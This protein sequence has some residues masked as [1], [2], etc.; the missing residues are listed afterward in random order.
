MSILLLL[1]LLLDSTIGVATGNVVPLITH[2][3]VS[4]LGINAEG[5]DISRR[6]KPTHIGCVYI[7]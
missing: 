2:L 4:L 6:R 5:T 7:V 3:F 1:L